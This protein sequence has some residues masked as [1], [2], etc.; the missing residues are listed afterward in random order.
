MPEDQGSKFYGPFSSNTMTTQFGRETQ[1]YHPFA[2]GVSR[3]HV[4]VAD[5][6][7]RGRV[8]C[9]TFRGEFVSC[10]DLWFK[11]EEDDDKATNGINGH[12]EEET[13]EGETDETDLE[14]WKDLELEV[15][16]GALIVDGKG[17]VVFVGRGKPCGMEEYTSMEC[18]P[19]IYAYDQKTEQATITQITGEIVSKIEDARLLP[20]GCIALADQN[21]IHLLDPT[22]CIVS[23]LDLYHPEG[24][25]ESAAETCSCGND[26]GQGSFIRYPVRFTVYTQ[27]NDIVLPVS[28]TK[29]GAIKVLDCKKQTV[30]FQFGSLGLGDGQFNGN[31]SCNGPYNYPRD[32]CVDVWG[33]IIVSDYGNCRV[34]MFDKEGRFIKHVVTKESGLH[35]PIAVRTSRDGRVVVLNAAPPYVQIF[36]YQP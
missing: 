16:S 12:D 21:Q 9:F 11:K 35:T 20:N 4:Y 28:I 25:P 6:A 23:S 33:R 31:A 32:L 34:H 30:C 13:Q 19:A 1:F 36:P 17:K 22:G 29:Y 8:Q 14:T 7:G 24:F 27:D 15:E 18:T 5:R 2:I 10:F 26:A 3:E